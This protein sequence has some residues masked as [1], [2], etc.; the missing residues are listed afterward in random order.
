MVHKLVLVGA[1]SVTFSRRL[2]GNIPSWPELR[3]SKCWLVDHNTE[4][5]GL[6]NGST[7]AATDG[8]AKQLAVV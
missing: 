8:E 2:I 6:T 5:L 7:T 1:G 3:D 4:C